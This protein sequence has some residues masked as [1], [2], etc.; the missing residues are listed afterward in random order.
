[1]D[2]KLIIENKDEV[3]NMT[4]AWDKEKFLVPDGNRT[5]GLPDT[6]WAL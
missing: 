4:G 3:F 5:H 6:G 2:Y 1:M